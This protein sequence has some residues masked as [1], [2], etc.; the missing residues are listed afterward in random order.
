MVNFKKLCRNLR[1]EMV[2]YTSLNLPSIAKPALRLFDHIFSKTRFSSHISFLSRCLYHK[3]IPT[4]FKSSFSLHL[5]S[6]SAHQQFSR[7]VMSTCFKHSRRLMRI[8]IQSTSMHVQNIDSDISVI[9]TTLR[10]ACPPILFSA[11]ENPSLGVVFLRRCLRWTSLVDDFLCTYKTGGVI[12]RFFTLYSTIFKE[13]KV[14][15]CFSSITQVIIW[16]KI[17]NKLF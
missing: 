15:N 13:P 17:V 4:G 1:N 12:F 6:P 9:K 2:C 11:S 5:N 10:N 16:K 14:N 8:A 3:V 7:S